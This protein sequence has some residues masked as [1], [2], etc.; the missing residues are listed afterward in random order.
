MLLLLISWCSLNIFNI[1]QKYSDFYCPRFENF[2][3]AHAKEV[4]KSNQSISNTFLQWSKE[5]GD[6]AFVLFSSWR[7]HLHVV[8]TT[9]IKSV[10]SSSSILK[11]SQSTIDSF[12]GVD[13]LGSKSLLT[14]PGTGTW[15]K[16][17]KLCD[18]FFHSSGLRNSYQQLVDISSDLTSSIDIDQPTN[19][20]KSIQKHVSFVIAQLVMNIKDKHEFFSYSEKISNVFSGLQIK[21]R[22]KNTFWI[23]WMFRDTKYS[24]LQDLAAVR[25]YFKKHILSQNI[26]EVNLSSSFGALLQANVVADQLLVNELINDMTMFFFA[27]IDTSMHTI[28][29]AFYEL[30]RNKHILVALEK[31]ISEVRNFNIYS[32][33]TP[34]FL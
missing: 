3:F 1:R 5:S 29:F 33:P 2:L 16:K 10:L 34:I 22:N 6:T 31:E 17:R 25:S 26:E 21:M 12:C 8:E 23:P 27:G 30:L 24:I 14:E 18:P 9:K 28:N 4:A 15:L 7:V 20:T 11:P 19:L 32:Q 13:V